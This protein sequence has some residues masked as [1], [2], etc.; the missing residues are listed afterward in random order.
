MH[1]E[2]ESTISSFCN[3]QFGIHV[4]TR[5]LL[6]L[7]DALDLGIGSVSQKAPEFAKVLR[8]DA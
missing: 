2:G 7:V 5:A 3:C 1:I 8:R 6:L 4:T